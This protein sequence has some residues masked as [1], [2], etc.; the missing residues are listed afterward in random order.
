[1]VVGTLRIVLS[2]TGN[3]SLKGKR[4]V[5][6]RILDKVKHKF[7]AAIAEVEEQDVHRRAVLG[8]AVVSNDAGHAT[9]M[10]DGV[11]SFIAAATE[12]VVIDRRMEIVHVSADH[13]VDD[14]PLELVG[15]PRWLEGDEQ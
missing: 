15:N 11:A 12:A 2:L 13:M 14:L 8:V 10:L 3:D 4:K 9:S 7:N 1:M 5:L 6:R